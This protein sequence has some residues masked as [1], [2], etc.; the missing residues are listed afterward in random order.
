MPFKLLIGE[1]GET[2]KVNNTKGAATMTGKILSLKKGMMKGKLP[3][4]MCRTF[5]DVFCDQLRIFSVFFAI[6]IMESI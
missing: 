5:R 3:I 4:R 2:K 1:Y 6:K